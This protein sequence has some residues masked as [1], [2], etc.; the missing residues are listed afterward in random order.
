MDFLLAFIH[1]GGIVDIKTVSYIFE[2]VACFALLLPACHTFP[3]LCFNNG[4][5][6][7]STPSHFFCFWNWLQTCVDFAPSPAEF[8]AP[9]SQLW[10]PCQRLQSCKFSRLHIFVHVFT[11]VVA[12]QMST[13]WNI[14]SLD[15]KGMLSDFT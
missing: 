5:K 12:T 15:K 11:H 8:V 2:S 3:I 6:T 9:T 4:L 14:C 1:G 10:Q 13:E 7:P